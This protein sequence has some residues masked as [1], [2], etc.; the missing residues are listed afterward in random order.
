MVMQLWLILISYSLPLAAISGMTGFKLIP[1]SA[2]YNLLNG[3]SVYPD[4]S[5]P[6]HLLLLGK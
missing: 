1:P 4:I 2:L 3:A 5:D 6:S